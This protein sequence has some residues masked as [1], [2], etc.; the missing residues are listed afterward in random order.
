[1]CSP[2]QRPSHATKP[3]KK[4]TNELSQ[5]GFVSWLILLLQPNTGSIIKKGWNGAKKKSDHSG[6]GCVCSWFPGV[7]PWDHVTRL[8]KMETPHF[9]RGWVELFHSFTRIVRLLLVVILNFTAALRL[10]SRCSPW[11]LSEIPHR[12]HLFSTN[13][14]KK[15]HFPNHTTVHGQIDTHQNLPSIT[16]WSQL[17]VADMNEPNSYWPSAEPG[18]TL[19]SAAPENEK[20]ISNERTSGTTSRACSNLSF[21][22][23]DTVHKQNTWR[24]NSMLQ[25]L[26]AELDFLIISSSAP[27]LYMVS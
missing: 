27:R 7:L 6:V 25:I 5:W 9:Q 23:T 16:L 20:V 1:M 15:S 3:E 12:L 10:G 14:K 17:S 8:Y 18:I 24:L 11:T 22:A 26:L 21:K 13:S 4:K 2:G 19:F